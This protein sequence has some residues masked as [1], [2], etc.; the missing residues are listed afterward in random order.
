MANI[1]NPGSVPESE[2][3]E[4][5]AVRQTLVDGLVNNILAANRKSVRTQLLLG[6]RGIGKMTLLL[7]IETELNRAERETRAAEL[8]L[9]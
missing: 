1:Y 6:P 4:T 9:R 2:R 8:N 3:T 7:A 5:F